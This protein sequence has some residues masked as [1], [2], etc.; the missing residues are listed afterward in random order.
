MDAAAK[1]LQFLSQR[2]LPE[3]PHTLSNSPDWRYRPPAVES[4]KHYEEWDNPRLQYMTLISHAE[5]GPLLTRSYHDMR[6][7]P[8]PAHRDISSL[9]KAG[10]EKKKLSLS[11]YKNKKTTGATAETTPEPLSARKR[12]V[13]N[14]KVKP[15]SDSA[16]RADASR[17]RDHSGVN[18][19]PAVDMR[20]VN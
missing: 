8:R 7:E 20:Y 10:G 11:D 18:S 6:V 16:G 12:E 3:L 2:V 19:K 13:A 9:A 1:S 15:S 4:K 14:E 17:S 5:R